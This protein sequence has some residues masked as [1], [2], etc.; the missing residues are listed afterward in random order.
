MDCYELISI[1]LAAR[2]PQLQHALQ[3]VLKQASKSLQTDSREMTRHVCHKLFP[4]S[5]GNNGW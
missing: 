5:E 3:G 4:H 2:W 1:R